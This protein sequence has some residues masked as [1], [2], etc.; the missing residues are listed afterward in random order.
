[1]STQLGELRDRI[2]RLVGDP[3]EE[4]YSPEIV[5]DGIVAAHDAILPWVPK[6]GQ[7]SFTGDGSATAFAVPSDVYALEA[8]IVDST[9]E[10]IPPAIFSPG[11]YWGSTT[12]NS[13]DWI[14]YP[15]GYV[16]FSK[17]I[18]SNATYSVFYA[19][20]WGVPDL[21]SQDTFVL[22]PPDYVMV[23][24]AYYAAAYAILPS[25]VSVSE[26]RQFGTRVDSGNPEHN[27][28][29]RASE[30]LLKLFAAEMNRHPK[31]QRPQR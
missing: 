15:S 6:T 12:V 22:E 7:D 19:A 3:A 25:A 26:I 28:M 1:M 10:T 5:I 23:G 31:H 27:P 29:Q 4:G 18:A 13:N 14:E 8:I 11:N 20:R 9:G 17:A 21:T 24:M 30:Y 2:Y 16:T